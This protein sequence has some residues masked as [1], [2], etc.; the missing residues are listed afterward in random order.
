[1]YTFA[2]PYKSLR[3]E[4]RGNALSTSFSSAALEFYSESSLTCIQHLRMRGFKR[5]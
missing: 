1:M 3:P 5:I 4:E 2:M